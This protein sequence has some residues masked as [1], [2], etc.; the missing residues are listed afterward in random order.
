MARQ[1]TATCGRGS[2]RTARAMQGA[3]QGAV[4]VW[5]NGHLDYP[6]NLARKLGR[7]DLKI[8]SPQWVE[9]RRWSGLTFPAIDIDH[10]AKLTEEQW[11]AYRQLLPYLR[12]AQRR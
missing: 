1:W 4:Y 2:G 5:V 12:P 8:V 7:E 11:Q 10:A 9:D 3:P 6:K